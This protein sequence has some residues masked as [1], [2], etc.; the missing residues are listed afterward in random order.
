VV[1]SCSTTA[2]GVLAA[3]S[4]SRSMRRTI[5]PATN[6]ACCYG[7]N[8]VIPMDRGNCIAVATSGS[9][10]SSTCPNDGRVQRV[11]KGWEARDFRFR[12]SIMQGSA[13][14]KGQSC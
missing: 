9:G 7:Y 13:T 8:S 10:K 3:A 4:H 2:E 1:I 11:G 6:H 5:S 14:R 12:E